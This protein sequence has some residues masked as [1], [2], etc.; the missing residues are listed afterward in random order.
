MRRRKRFPIVQ[1]DS[2]TWVLGM[3]RRFRFRVSCSGHTNNMRFLLLQVMVRLYC[4]RMAP[5]LQ[6]RCCTALY[7]GLQSSLFADLSFSGELSF[8]FMGTY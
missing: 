8:N 2:H 7:N 6:P 3:H 1:G 5:E 4:Y